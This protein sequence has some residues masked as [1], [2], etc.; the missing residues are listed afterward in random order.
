MSEERTRFPI[1]PQERHQTAKSSDDI[2]AVPDENLP[3]TKDRPQD[4]PL[5]PQAREH[6]D[7]PEAPDEQADDD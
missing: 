3:R 2:A 4:K 7:K 6:E 5:P 1:T